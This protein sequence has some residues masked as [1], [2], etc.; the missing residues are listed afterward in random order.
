MT[1]PQSLPEALAL[2]NACLNGTA[3]VLMTAGFVN[4]RRGRV[5]V[6]R[7]FMLSAIVASCL[8]LISYLTRYGLSGDTPFRGQ[9]VMRP[10]YFTILISHVLLAVTVVPLVLRTLY[11]ALKER[12]AEHRRI[13]KVT[14]PIWWYVSVTGVIVYLMLYQWPVA[15]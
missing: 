13:A 5:R 8:F 10:I 1:A 3:A 6:H 12:F 11:L 14:L 7:A 2:L 4:I 15:T 9:G